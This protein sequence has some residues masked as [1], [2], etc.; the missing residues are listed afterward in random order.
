MLNSQS[1]MSTIEIVPV[2]AIFIMLVNF[3]LG[4][5]G[6]IHSGILNSIAARNYAFETFRNRANLIYLRDCVTEAGPGTCDNFASPTQYS[7]VGFRFHG[8]VSEKGRVN[9]FDATLRSIKFTERTL[10]SEIKGVNEHEF[11]VKQIV[12]GK[13]ATDSGID[14]GTNP[15][16]I[17]TVHGICLNTKCGD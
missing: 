14:E 15:V 4:F 1:G 11:A 16:W 9:T 3:S 2:L 7:N 10:A 6:V 5:F 12:E 13:R 17:K 8:V